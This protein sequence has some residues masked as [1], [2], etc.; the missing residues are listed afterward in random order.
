MFHSTV[1]RLAAFLEISALSITLAQSGGAQYKAGFLHLEITKGV[2]LGSKSASRKTRHTQKWCAVRESY[3]VISEELGEVRITSFP[4]PW[5]KLI[6]PGQL[7]VFDVFLL[8]SDFKIERPTRYYRQGLHLLR[9]GGDD[10]KKADKGKGKEVDRLPPQPQG[11]NDT[12]GG[13]PTLPGDAA[14]ISTLGS[15]R[16]RVS[17]VFKRKKAPGSEMPS[18][19]SG[20]GSGHPPRVSTDD[21]ASTVSTASSHSERAQTPMLDPSTNTNPLLDPDENHENPSKKKTHNE[22]SKHTFYI[23]N[24]Q[25]KLKITARNERQML[26][27]IAALEKA[28][29][30]CHF[31]LRSRFDSF[32]P[33]RLNVAA[34]WLVDG[35]SHRP[36]VCLLPELMD[37]IRD[38]RDYFW[39]L[40]RAILLAKESIYIHD[41]WLSPGNSIRFLLL[42]WVLTFVGPFQNFNCADPGKKD[43]DLIGCSRGRLKRA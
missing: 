28:A 42:G 31:T 8:D 1:N 26:Q 30:T 35:V 36:S 9:D 18:R 2:G 12:D 5:H 11:E 20:S 15:L 41:W 32:S 14:C 22:A 19:P 3:L 4:S 17:S 13:H 27:W 33:V 25:M 16:N 23:E 7:T 29:S 34:Q 37:M 24:S 6:H 38:Q 40:S 10:E 39:N 43:T 21:T